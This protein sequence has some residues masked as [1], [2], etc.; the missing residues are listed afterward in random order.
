MILCSDVTISR[1]KI[2]SGLIALVL[3]ANC[4]RTAR[5]RHSTSIC[6]DSGCLYTVSSVQVDALIASGAVGNSRGNHK[7]YCAEYFISEIIF[8][9]AVIFNLAAWTTKFIPIDTGGKKL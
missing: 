6:F 9:N 3:V 2:P 8:N 5:L 7:C 4:K 1:I